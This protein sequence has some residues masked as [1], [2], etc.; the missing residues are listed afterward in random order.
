MQAD[1]G[2]S[3]GGGGD[4]KL[5]PD[6]GTDPP[7]EGQAFFILQ[8]THLRS[9]EWPEAFADY[10]VLVT[11][12]SLGADDVAGIR[13]DLPG[14][15]LL[16]YTNV[17]DMPL[18]LH[19]ANAYWR[20]LEA[21]FDSSLC[22]RNLSTGNVVRIYGAD[23]EDLSVGT[24]AYIMSREAADVLVAF[25][26]DVT[27]T[28]GWDG[29]YVD[30]CTALYPSWKVS[31]LLDITTN[32]DIDDDG[33]GDLPASLLAQHETWRPYFTQRLREELGEA[34]VIVGNSGGPLADAALN[35]ITLEGVGARFTVA[36]AGAYLD[37]AEAAT[38]RPFLAILWATTAES[39]APSRELADARES[40][41]FGVIESVD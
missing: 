13:A 36:E 34:A 32:F 40:V 12:P 16:A 31:Q 29:M 38:S 20:G 10:D 9:D 27:M 35:G 7:V 21:V 33:F 3:S 41:H 25:H 8:G 11:T 6:D 14:V 2:G 28:A 18:G 24:P 1:P 22:I 26:R 23:P 4:D 37:E 30:Q 5:P 19:S 17:Q 39:E 15:R